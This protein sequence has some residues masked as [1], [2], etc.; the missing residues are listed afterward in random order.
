MLELSVNVTNTGIRVGKEVIQIYVSFPEGVVE[1]R[2]LALGREEIDFPVRVLRNFD[3]IS[4]EPGESKTVEMTLSRKDLSYW[5]VRAQNWVLPTDGK[6][7]IWAGRS[8]RDLPL[9]AE[10]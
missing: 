2:G 1:H 8:S 10:F 7:K 3:K 9:V 6:F 5:S 4:L